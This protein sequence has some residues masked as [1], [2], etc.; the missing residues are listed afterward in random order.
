MSPELMP[1]DNIVKVAET[2]SVSSS[3]QHLQTEVG[4]C[5]V[6]I[7][8]RQTKQDKGRNGFLNENAIIVL[9]INFIFNCVYVCVSLDENVHGGTGARGSLEEGI[10][11]L[12]LESQVA[13]SP[14]YWVLV[15]IPESI[16]KEVSIA[17]RQPHL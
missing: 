3:F 16:V 11:A 4:V 2:A 17:N 7:K 6:I 10:G 14:Q 12:E 9:K 1:S 8:V 5:K 13:V 15:I